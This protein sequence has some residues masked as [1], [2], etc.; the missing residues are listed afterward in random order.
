MYGTL[1]LIKIIYGSSGLWRL[2]KRAYILGCADLSGYFMVLEETSPN[3]RQAENRIHLYHWRNHP[4]EH[5]TFMSGCN[6]LLENR[7]KC[8]L[9]KIIWERFNIPKQAFCF[10]RVCL[11]K[12]PISDRIVEWN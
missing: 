12:L 6:W 7:G 5:Y 2:L 1:L 8:P 11:G 9:A 10:W 4:S 3:T